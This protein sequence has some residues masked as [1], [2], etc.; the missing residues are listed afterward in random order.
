VAAERFDQLILARLA[1]ENN[2][3]NLVAKKGDFE[4]EPHR[5]RTC[6]RLIKRQ[7]KEKLLIAC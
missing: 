2:V 6:N 1:D 7:P 5:T 4:R 3:G